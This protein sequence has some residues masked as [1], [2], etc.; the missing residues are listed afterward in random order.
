M[1]M[2]SFRVFFFALLLAASPLLQVARCQSEAESDVAEAVDV[3]ELGIVGE[4][5]PDID[6]ESFGPAPGVETVCVFPKNSAK[7]VVAG[8]ET[9]LL[10]GMEN[11]GGSPVNVIAIQASVHLPFDHRMLVQ[12]LT[13]QTFKNATVSSSVQATFPYIFAVSQYL[14]PG[15]FDLVGTIVYEIDQYPY[16]NTFYNG[17]IE[18]VEAGG[19]VS[20]ESVFLVTLGVALIVLLGLWLHGQ[21]QHITKKTKKAPKVEV[22]TRSTDAS[23]DEWLQFGLINYVGI[24]EN[25]NTLAG[26]ISVIQ[27]ESIWTPYKARFPMKILPFRGGALV[28]CF[29]LSLLFADGKTVEVVGVGECADC[30]ENNLETSQAFSGLRVNIDCKPENGKYFKTRGS[31]EL[32]K[33]GNFK[34]SLPEDMVKDGGL[35]E[36]CYAQLH[37]VSAAPCPVHDGMESAK[38]VLI[39]SSGGEKHK[40]GLK[41]KLR[42][43]PVTCASATLWP[44]FKF[45]PM[46][47]WSHPPLPKWNHPPLPTW[48]HPPFPKWNHPPLPKLFPPIY[49]KPL[50]PPVPVYKPPPVPVY[51]K[52]LPPPVPVYKPPPV[53]VYVKPL[54]PPVPIYKPPPVPVYKKPLPP[55]VPV[56]KKPNPPPVPVYKKPNPPPVPVYKKPHPPPVP[57]YKKPLPPPVPIY[58][59]PPVPVYKKPLP[60]PVPIYKPPPVPVY[61]KPLPPPVPVYKK[62]LP[63]PVPVYKPPTPVY[64]KPLPP[65]VPVY[66]PK[67]LPPIPYKPLPP[68]PKIPPFPK[69]PC[70]PL[71]NLPPLPKIPPKYFHHPPLPK[72]PPKYFHHPPLPKLP[73]LPK[74]PPKYFHHHPKFGKWPPLPPFSP[75]HP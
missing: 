16:Q 55:P 33:Q 70:P 8:E 17:T 75:H 65:P 53:P 43:S 18:V 56:Y 27:P 40:L 62:P 5:V 66:K 73:P 30:A 60:P 29:F 38:I 64:T 13:A 36:E 37:S 15:T 67:P 22:G 12:N 41:G 6:G 74:I 57:V 42:F 11:V 32:D 45:P 26:T 7:L 25:Q 35:K 71:P 54:P 52:P 63:P 48:N 50:P 46:P 14:Q 39:K 59:P 10:V 3:G 4:D 47:K 31:G 28:C 58:K 19:F 61:K 21:F 44:H 72:I 2:K 9:E 20:V 68:L 1:A 69:K 49:K 23:M 51:E 34:V 24:K